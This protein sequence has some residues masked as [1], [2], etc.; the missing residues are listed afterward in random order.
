MRMWNVDTKLLCKK[1][2]LG[3]HVEMHMFVGSINKG[4][5]LKG[6]IDKGLVEISHIKQ[7]HEDL[8]NEMISRG[9]NHNSELPECELWEEGNVD[10]EESISELIKRCPKCKKRILNS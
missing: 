3:E 9:M 10:V 6:F 4:K 7:R 8:K 5:S 2:L 1:H